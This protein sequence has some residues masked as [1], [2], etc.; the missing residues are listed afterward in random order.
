[1]VSSA[2]ATHEAATKKAVDAVEGTGTEGS[3]KLSDHERADFKQGVTTVLDY[4]EGF[5]RG[6]PR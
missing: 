3:G 5:W 4:L 1:M 2:L 6:L